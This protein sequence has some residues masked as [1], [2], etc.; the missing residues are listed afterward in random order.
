MRE[1]SLRA[2]VPEFSAR[3]LGIFTIVQLFPHNSDKMLSQNVS[4]SILRGHLQDVFLESFSL[5]FSGLGRLV[6]KKA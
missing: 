4:F 2:L 5:T 6:L 3:I 1:Q